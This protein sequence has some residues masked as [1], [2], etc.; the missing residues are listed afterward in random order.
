MSLYDRDALTNHDLAKA[1]AD[2]AKKPKKKKKKK[3]K[4][5]ELTAKLTEA[6]SEI[7]RLRRRIQTMRNTISEAIEPES[8]DYATDK[9]AWDI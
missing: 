3:A 4:I 2:G 1:I 5:D 9:E 7:D 6:Y 8:G